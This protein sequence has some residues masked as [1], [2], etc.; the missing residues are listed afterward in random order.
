M[1]MI[2]ITIVVVVVVVYVLFILFYELMTEMCVQRDKR[3][4]TL[5]DIDVVVLTQLI[6][7]YQYDF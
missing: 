5:F 3:S 6:C 4:S 7:D 2:I 1:T